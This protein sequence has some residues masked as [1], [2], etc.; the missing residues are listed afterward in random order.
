MGTGLNTLHREGEGMEELVRG[1]IRRFVAE[2]PANRFPEG[3]KR[4]FDDPLVGFAAADDPLFADYKRIIGDFHLTPAE[5]MAG[6]PGKDAGAPATV[7]CWAL[8]IT[9]RTRELNRRESRFPSREW[10]ETRSR[11]EQF[12]TLLRR[13]LVAW[14]TGRGYLAVAPQL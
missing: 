3:G 9:R 7:I 4:Y 5:I 6:S 1:E 14:L 2:S 10:A 12:N 11:G 8:P 13:H